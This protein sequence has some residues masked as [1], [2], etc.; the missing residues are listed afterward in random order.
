MA[1]VAFAGVHDSFWTHAGDM[2][3][4]NRL[5]RETFV[6]LH[7]KPLLEMLLDGLRKRFP[8]IKPELYPDIPDLGSLDLAEVQRSEY[9]FS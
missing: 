7:S 4:L 8:E 9:F 5:L 1:G 6:E 2:P 3:V